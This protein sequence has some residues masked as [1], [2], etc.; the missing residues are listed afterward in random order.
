[1]CWSNP[2]GSTQTFYS[3]YSPYPDLFLCYDAADTQNQTSVILTTCNPS[4]RSIVAVTPQ[5]L[6]V[7]PSGSAL[8][9]QPRKSKSRKSCPFA[10]LWYPLDGVR[11]E[12][13]FIS[14]SK[15]SMKAAFGSVQYFFCFYTGI[16]YLG[17]RYHP[18]QPT[19]TL[20]ERRSSCRDP[21]SLKR[22]HPAIIQAHNYE[23]RGTKN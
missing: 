11:R 7:L 13:Y 5:N 10:L 4:Q 21:T 19:S 1:M 2:T 18:V 16:I 9:L 12:A 20:R 22:A 6:T 17:Q 3:K 15:A 14:V 8:L 23:L